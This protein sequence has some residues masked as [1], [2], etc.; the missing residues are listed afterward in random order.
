MKTIVPAQAEANLSMRLV[1]GQSVASVSAALGRLLRDA[2]VP[3]ASIELELLAGSDP[4]Q[5]ASDSSAIQLAADAFRK[6]TGV[7][8]R[9]VR[10]GGSL[11]LLP[12][13]GR[14]DIPAVL[15]GF[16]LPEGNIH[17]PN[18]R[19]LLENLELGLSTARELFLAYAGLR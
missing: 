13:L 8:P 10:T 9:L 4:A 1:P 3:G 6:A 18:E 14:R 16:D 11:P 5:V 19:F 17:A 7:T 12:A 2:V 15:T